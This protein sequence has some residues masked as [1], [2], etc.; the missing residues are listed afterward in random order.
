VEGPLSV[1][2]FEDFLGYR[3]RRQK[4]A[5]FGCRTTINRTSEDHGRWNPTPEVEDSMA[6]EPLEPQQ[7][8]TA[9]KEQHTL[10]EL[11][12]LL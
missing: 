11:A 8:A 2:S 4:V 6:T 10:V 9:V 12:R 5:G 1:I 7:T 3:Q